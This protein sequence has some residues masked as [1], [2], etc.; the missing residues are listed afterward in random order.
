MRVLGNAAEA[1]YVIVSAFNFS[2]TDWRGLALDKFASYLKKLD[3]TQNVTEE[4]V[5]KRR[6]CY[7]MS[8]RLHYVAPRTGWMNWVRS[9]M[10]AGARQSRI[11]SIWQST[12]IG[13]VIGERITERLSDMGHS[14]EL[15]SILESALLLMKEDPRHGDLYYKILSTPL[16]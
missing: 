9:A 2:T 1:D 6:K 10:K 5:G 4:E 14:M 8:M 15:L 13:I 3:I 7:C 16:L 12:M 11:S